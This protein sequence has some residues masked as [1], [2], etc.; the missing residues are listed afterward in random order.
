MPKFSL[1]CHF[2]LQRPVL[3]ALPTLPLATPSLLA[4]TLLLS[5]CSGM[6]APVVRE[7]TVAEQG[8]LK[9]LVNLQDRLDRVAAPLLISNPELCKDSARNLLGFTAKNKYSYS[10]ELSSASHQ[11]LGLDDRLQVI[12]VIP[13]SGAARVGLRKGDKLISVNDQALPEGQN[14]E[15]QAAAIIAPL[16][17][18]KANV[19]LAVMRNNIKL[20]FN[21]PLTLACAFSVELG[22]AD[23]V[24]AY[25]DGRR[26]VVTRG[27]VMFAKTDVELAY[28][29]AKEMAHSVLGHQ[30]KQQIS[31]TMSAIID[32]MVLLHPDMRSMSGTAGIKPYPQELDAAADTLSLY[33]LARASFRVDGAPPFWQRLA[34]Q[35]PAT[36]LNSYT[37]IH[38]AIAYRV[39]AM[40]KAVVELKAKFAARKPLTP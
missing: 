27:L 35:Y 26:I 5:A 25:S 3:L 19:K 28:V 32:N 16:V 10:D 9:S 13:G 31:S 11:A 23:N 6:N 21:V 12:R 37:A 30:S 14:A 2:N 29:V 22:N 8:A 33:M 24:N 34:L 36:V 17:T 40:D 20:A 38:P 39:S 4:L 15:T 7:P 18:G 1:V